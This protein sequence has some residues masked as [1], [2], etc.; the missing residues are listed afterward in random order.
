MILLPIL[1]RII[2]MFR[3]S[4]HRNCIVLVSWLKFLINM[5]N[6][7]F[8]TFLRINIVLNKTNNEGFEHQK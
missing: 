2:C 3:S 5:I 6:N 7:Q 1:R 4:I 8:R